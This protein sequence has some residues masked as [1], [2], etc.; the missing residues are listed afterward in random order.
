MAEVL[1]LK[2]QVLVPFCEALL[3]SCICVN[4]CFASCL[5]VKGMLLKECK[6]EQGMG[7]EGST[8]KRWGMECKQKKKKR[9]PHTSQNLFLLQKCKFIYI[10]IYSGVGML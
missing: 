8:R 4:G 10:Y 9:K 1:F 5:K 7:G 3:T 2:L 6:G